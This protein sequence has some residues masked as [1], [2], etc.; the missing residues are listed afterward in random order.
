MAIH[1]MK[2]RVS[3]ERARENTQGVEGVC[4]SKEEQQY[5]LTVPPMLPGTKPPIR[6]MALAAYIAEN[7]LVRYQWEER[8]L[9][10]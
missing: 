5:E 4:S 9:V 3:N 2:H 7:G 10:L 6:L 8:P 1:C